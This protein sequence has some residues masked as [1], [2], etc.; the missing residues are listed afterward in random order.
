[1]NVEAIGR[2]L[3]DSVAVVG[4]A[5]SGLAPAVEAL[6]P[7][8]AALGLTIVADPWASHRLWLL[9]DHGRF[10]EHGVPILYLFNGQ[11]GD[12]HRPG[13]ESRKIAVDAVARVARFVALVARAL[14][15]SPSPQGAAP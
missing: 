1:M 7:G 11:H 4:A 8:A 9:G 2:N 13:D 15:A 3:H 6:A 14:T 10:R 12:L 5:Q